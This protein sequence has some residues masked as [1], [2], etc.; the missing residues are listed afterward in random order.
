MNMSQ[1]QRVVLAFGLAFAFASQAHATPATADSVRALFQLMHVDTVIDG[2]YT[3]MQKS[4]S[5]VFELDAQKRGATPARQRIE[6]KAM[7]DTMAM[8]RSEYNWAVMEPEMIDVYQKTFSEE[9]ITA[10]I[11]FYS[12]PA[13]QAAINKIPQLTQTMMASTQAHMQAILPRVR[14]IAEKARADA[15]AADAAR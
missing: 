11:N 14:A 4:M 2:V 7:D 8:V 12:T 15:E 1:F 3:S 6:A 9:E 5:Q 10:M 13:G